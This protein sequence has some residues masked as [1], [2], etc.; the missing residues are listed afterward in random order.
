MPKATSGL[1]IGPWFKCPGCGGKNVLWA[2]KKRRYTCRKCGTL[3]MADH[4]KRTTIVSP[5]EA[6]CQ[7]GI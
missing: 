3:F 2:A 4:Q 5:P 6:E 1:T 7:L